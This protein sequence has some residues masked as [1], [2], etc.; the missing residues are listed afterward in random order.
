LDAPKVAC[1]SQSRCFSCKKISNA[2]KHTL[3]S[4]NVNAAASECV[5][6]SPLSVGW[7]SSGSNGGGGGGGFFFFAFFSETGAMR[8]GIL[9]LFI[10]FLF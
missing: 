2:N 10:D 3:A 4:V 9:S 7:K 8:M 6:P 1:W 5:P